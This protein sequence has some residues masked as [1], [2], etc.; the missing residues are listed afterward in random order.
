MVTSAFTLSSTNLQAVGN[1][2]FRSEATAAANAAL[3]Q[4]IGGISSTAPVSQSINV[5]LANDGTNPYT[6]SIVP[7]C[8]TSLA[9]AGVAPAH[10]GSGVELGAGMSLVTS[11]VGYTTVWDMAATVQDNNTGTSVVV[12][13]GVRKQLTS[14]CL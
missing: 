3:E 14:D 10:S 9:V 11:I 1:M 13:Q 4:A 2:Q 6:V 12:H 8:L 5:Y 7:T